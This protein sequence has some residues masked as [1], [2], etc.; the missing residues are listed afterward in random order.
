MRDLQR[1]RSWQHKNWKGD[2]FGQLD[3]VE[4]MSRRQ[5]VKAQLDAFVTASEADLAPLL[6]AELREAVEGYERLKSDR[7]AL[8]FLDLL[9]KA[10]DLVRDSPEVRRE[11]QGRFTRFYVD[12]AQDT[13]PLQAELLLLLAADDPDSTD[14]RTARPVPG[15]LFLVG[16]PKQ[17]LYRFRRADVALYESIKA[18]LLAGGAELLHLSTSFR[19]PPSLQAFVNAAF[20]PAIGADL[21]ASGYIPLQNIAPKLPVSRPSSSCQYPTPTASMVR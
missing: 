2:T 9:I 3:A 18:R 19:S 10:R 7:G 8:D 21:E 14:W 16:D 15:K 11:L 13:D 17:S 1:R 12:E 6:H 4:V 5:A 20:A